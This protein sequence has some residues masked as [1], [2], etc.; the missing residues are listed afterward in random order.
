MSSSLINV[1]H[2]VAIQF[3]LDITIKYKY[4]ILLFYCYVK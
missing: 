2:L 3:L 4:I 1:L